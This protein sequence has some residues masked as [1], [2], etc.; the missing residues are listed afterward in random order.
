M[1]GKRSI[2]PCC[3]ESYVAYVRDPANGYSSSEI[4]LDDG[5]ELSIR[6]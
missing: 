2:C 1:D 6:G 3:V 5:L 4:P